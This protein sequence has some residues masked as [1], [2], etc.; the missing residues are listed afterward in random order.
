MLQR[1]VQHQSDSNDC[2]MAVFVCER[3]SL[4]VLEADVVHA[5]ESSQLRYRDLL[6]EPKITSVS[7]SGAHSHSCSEH[8]KV[9][10]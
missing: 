9:P 7:G 8:K 6:P 3:G 4:C 1:T 5:T 2:I 10:L